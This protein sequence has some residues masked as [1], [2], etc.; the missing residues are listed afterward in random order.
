MTTFSSETSKKA[1]TVFIGASTEY[2]SV[3]G[4]RIA[5]AAGTARWA[6]C[7]HS[8]TLP[9]HVHARHAWVHLQLPRSKAAPRAITTAVK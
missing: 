4:R 7:S 5:P 2:A 8:P 3:Q 1:Y 9:S 6:A